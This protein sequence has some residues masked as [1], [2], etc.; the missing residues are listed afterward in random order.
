M[1]DGDKIKQAALG[2]SHSIL[3]ALGI[4]VP[5]DPKLH[6]GC[7]I[8]GPGRNNHRFRFANEDGRG[9]WYCNSCGYGDLWHLIMQCLG[10]DFIEALKRVG[11]ILGECEPDGPTPKK[12]DESQIRD[13]LNKVWTASTP[14]TGSD[15][16]SRYLHSRLLSLTPK[17]VRFCPTCYESETKK[18]MPAMVA[19]VRNVQGVPVTIHRTYLDGPAKAKISSPKKLMPTAGR[20]QTGAIRL[21]PPAG[22][23]IGISEGV[24]SA[25]AAT[26]LWEIPTWAAISTAIMESFIPPEPIRRV[27]IFGDADANYAGQ[28]AVYSLANK[29]YAKDYIVDVQI[30]ET[31]DWADEIVRLERKSA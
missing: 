1:I 16:A 13:A 6:T 17:D 24:E 29:L 4:D 27:V 2:K 25:I 7:P 15:L 3:S 12:R 30:P 26:Q 21:F 28:K 14:L 5:A 31:G 23:L 10:I 11:E 20:V 19:L 8:C 22:D 18:D 9:T